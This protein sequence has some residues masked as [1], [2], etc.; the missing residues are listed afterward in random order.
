MSRKGDE[1]I[2]S[3]SKSDGSELIRKVLKSGGL[4]KPRYGV[5]WRCIEWK[6]SGR[7]MNERVKRKRIRP[8]W[9]YLLFGV[10]YAETGDDSHE[11]R[12]SD[13]GARVQMC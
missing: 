3:V 4:A 7:R 10:Q 9:D 2:R 5:V 8:G 6:K 12:D 13:C 1:V 11:E